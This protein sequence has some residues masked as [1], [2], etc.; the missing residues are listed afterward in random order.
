MNS[1]KRIGIIVSICVVIVCALAIVH[2]LT[3]V[4]VPVNNIAIISEGETLYADL[5]NLS[6]SPVSG[7][8]TNKKKETKT[9]TG[10]GILLRD[11]LAENHVSDYSSVKVISDDE[12]SAEVSKEEVESTDNAYL[13][14]EDS[15]ARLYVFG[16]FDSKRNVLN[17]KR[18]EIVK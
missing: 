10:D 8:V 9:I 11:I 14:V 12:Y 3:R 17:V 4:K 15:A 2:N 18:I 1:K 16:D 5:D 6:L 13:L 7:E